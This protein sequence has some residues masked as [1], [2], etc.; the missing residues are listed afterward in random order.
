MRV[1]L[2]PPA[3]ILVRDG[4][5]L[6]LYPEEA[7]RLAGISAEIVRLAA[8]PISLEQL[9]QALEA[10]FGSPEEISALDAATAAVQELEDRG[11][12]LLG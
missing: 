3:D 11:V 6:L 2:N 8:G 4:E 10:R 1:R 7:I 9:A 5:A 12:L